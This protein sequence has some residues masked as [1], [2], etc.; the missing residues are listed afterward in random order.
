MGAFR[1]KPE[2]RPLSVL[3]LRLP[4][5]RAFAGWSILES[6]L[7]CRGDAL[8][9]LEGIKKDFKQEI[10]EH[11]TL[12]LN[13]KYIEGQAFL[14]TGNDFNASTIFY[15][16]LN[17]NS[18][19]SSN[20]DVIL[21]AKAQ[22]KLGELYEKNKQYQM[23]IGHFKKA[24]DEL[25]AYNIEVSWV[26]YYNLSILCMYKRQYDKASV[27]LMFVKQKNTK[28]Q[29]LE[30]LLHMF[31]E[32]YKEGIELLKKSKGSFIESQDTEMILR[33]SMAT[34]Y[35]A[36]FSPT[37]YAD[38]MEKN[39]VSLIE[40]DLIQKRY[41]DKV[42]IEL[43]VITM[44]YI[45]STNIQGDNNFKVATYLE[46][47][48]NF[49][50]SHD[51]TEYKHITLLLRAMYLKSNKTNNPKIIDELLEQAQNIMKERELRNLDL[52]NIFYERSLLHDEKNN[53]LS[54]H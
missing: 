1:D 35:F 19:V 3:S 23:A 31:S 4:R 24:I 47:L 53:L 21:R 26:V 51:F 14:I 2:R 28:L 8:S 44:H 9:Q 48:I 22:H 49:E 33:S 18:T 7:H 32:N 10:D 11:P 36:P 52:Y 12:K 38:R 5:S 39:T 37:K 34:L 54:K 20:G 16:M 45:I 6:T 42:Q 41:E 27:Y 15:Q 13:L 43:L 17:L 29:Y 30:A 46:L 40:S 50:D 25:E